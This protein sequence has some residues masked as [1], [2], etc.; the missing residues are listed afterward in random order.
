MDIY[1]LVGGAISF[2]LAACGVNLGSVNTLG[3]GALL[4]TLSFIF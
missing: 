3:L 2:A 1:F 4:V